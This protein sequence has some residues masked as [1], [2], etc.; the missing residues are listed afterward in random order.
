[1]YFK[2]K[3]PSPMA[4]YDKDRK[5]DTFCWIIKPHHYLMNKTEWVPDRRITAERVASETTQVFQSNYFQMLTRQKMIFAVFYC[6]SSQCA[7]LP[8][9]HKCVK[10]TGNCDARIITRTSCFLS[11]GFNRIIISRQNNT[12]IIPGKAP[13][14]N[15]C[16][17][18]SCAY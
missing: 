12:N 2:G 1:M 5:K 6:C 8:L 15:R 17:L 4:V 16:V 9:F 11:Y 13:M 10:F 18:N 3:S 7:D 14:P